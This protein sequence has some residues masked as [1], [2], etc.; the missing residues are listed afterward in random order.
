[1]VSKV[2][3]NSLPKPRGF[4]CSYAGICSEAHVIFHM[5]YNVLI[6]FFFSK[7]TFFILLN[8]SFLWQGPLTRLLPGA[9]VW[10]WVCLCIYTREKGGPGLALSVAGT[11]MFCVEGAR[12]QT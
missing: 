12:D 6:Q 11:V 4:L 8:I 5:S 9:V 3:D 2:S 7:L 1:M 10:V